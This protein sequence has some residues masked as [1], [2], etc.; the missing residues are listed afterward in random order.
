[1]ARTIAGSRTLAGARSAATDRLLAPVLSLPGTDG[2]N[3]SIA[4]AAV[5]N[6]TGSI[7]LQYLVEPAS[8]RP[9]GAYVLASMYAGSGLRAF[10]SF[11]LS[12]GVIRLT[13]SANGAA[14]TT[15]DSSAAIGRINSPQWVRITW[16]QSTKAVQFF[17]APASGAAPSSWTQLGV[18]GTINI[19]SIFASTEPLRMG[20]NST[21]TERFKGKYYRFIM[22][23]GINGTTVVDAN[24][25][26]AAPGSTSFTERSSNAATV[27]INTSGS[28]AAVIVG[29]TAVS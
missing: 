22:K 10:Q 29:R 23:N 18:D 2:N 17:T 27:T 28:P 1:M 24:F 7:D 21:A 8:W 13:L 15:A 4:N 6:V 16:N 19:A 20:S 5:L 26:N 12:T 11:I 25:G 3:A 9:T 14:T